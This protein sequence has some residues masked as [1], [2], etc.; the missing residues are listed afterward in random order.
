MQSDEPAI[1]HAPAAADHDVTW[2]GAIGC[3]NVAIQR[4]RRIRITQAVDHDEVGAA[5]DGESAACAS[6][7]LG[8]TGRRT[9]IEKLSA[10]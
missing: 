6:A 8:A 9:R 1:S 2:G 10:R 5:P 7:R 4:H 3:E